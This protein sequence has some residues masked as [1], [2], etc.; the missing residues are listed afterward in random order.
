M[1]NFAQIRVLNGN[2]DFFLLNINVTYD[3]SQTLSLSF[4]LYTY[5]NFGG[6]VEVM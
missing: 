4:S 2:I 6:L 3:Y 1:S 5:S